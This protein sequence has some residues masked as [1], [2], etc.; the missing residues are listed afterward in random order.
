MN[1]LKQQ[2][3]IYKYIHDQTMRLAYA[4]LT[5]KEIAEEM[6]FPESLRTVFAN[7]GY[8]GTL[9]HNAKAVYQFYF[10]WYD[11]NPANLDPLPPEDAAKNMWRIWVEQIKSCHAYKIVLTKASTDGLLKS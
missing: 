5:P 9:K 7:R 1:F 10:G 11:G 4:G 3:D 8:Y 2:R 6:V